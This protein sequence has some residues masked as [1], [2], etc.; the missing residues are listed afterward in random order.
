MMNNSDFWSFQVCHFKIIIRIDIATADWGRL[1]KLLYVVLDAII[2]L[3]GRPNFK[4]TASAIYLIHCT[5][6]RYIP[7]M[8]DT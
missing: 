3:I 6:C 8:F 7:L 5:Q 2:Y 1:Y 4:G